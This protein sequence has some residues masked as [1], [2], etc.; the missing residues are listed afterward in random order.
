MPQSSIPLFVLGPGRSGTSLVARLLHTRL[1][2]S[3]GRR[4]RPPNESNPNG[5][6]EDLDFLEANER[7]LRGETSLSQWR[8]WIGQF[9]RVR[10]QTGRPWGVK[11]PRIG[12]AWRAYRDTFPAYRVVRC[13]RP[14]E[15]VIQSMIRW[16]GFDERFAAEY[17]RVREEGI[18]C[19]C[20]G[21]PVLTLDFDHRRDED[22]VLALL[23]GFLAQD[24]LDVEKNRP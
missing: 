13:R 15:Q 10:E 1:D 5:F 19:L 8:A 23:S 12:Q 7:L 14:T 24:T 3:M 17:A 9:V 11:D 18:D 4:F 21:R 6:F 22:E 2:V 20:E 16:Y